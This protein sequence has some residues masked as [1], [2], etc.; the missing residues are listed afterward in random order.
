M[1]FS[2][3]SAADA[4]RAACAEANSS[5]AAP[6]VKVF[7]IP[8]GKIWISDIVFMPPNYRRNVTGLLRACPLF[9]RSCGNEFLTGKLTTRKLGGR[10][11]TNLFG[12][13]S[14]LSPSLALNGR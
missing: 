13:Q 8:A 12:D 3:N 2:S 14:L 9:V 1:P 11:A 4:P 10:P 6:S 7:F 5:S